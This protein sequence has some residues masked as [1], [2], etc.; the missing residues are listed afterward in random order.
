MEKRLSQPQSVGI[1]QPRTDLLVSHENPSGVVMFSAKSM[2]FFSRCSDN[3][4][5]TCARVSDWAQTLP[6]A[7]R[8]RLESSTERLVGREQRG[9]GFGFAWGQTI[10]GGQRG[11]LGVEHREE[12]G[13]AVLIAHARNFCS[14]HP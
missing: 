3:R 6:A 9:G 7:E 4:W 13:G 10:L 14:V 8:R 5:A 2:A 1:G 11:A 12:V